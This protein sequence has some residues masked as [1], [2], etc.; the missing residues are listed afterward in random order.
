M[1]GQIIKRGDKTWLLRIF[2]GRDGS[3]KRR[4]KNKT[5]RGNKKDAEAFL[6]KTQTQ[7]SCGTFV[8][9][10]LLTIDEYLDKW[11]EAAARPRLSERTFADYSEVL[12]RYV[13][14][15]LGSITLS[16]LQPLEIQ[17]LYSE[18]Q[19]RELSARTVRGAHVVLSSALKQAVQWRMLF[20][21]PA[22]CVE[23]PK[24]TRR[25]MKA[26]SPV[27]AIAFLAAAKHDPHGLVFAVG[28]VTGMRPEEY[29][30]LQWKDVDLKR[31]TATVQR[32]LCWR[33]QKGGGWYFGEPKTSQSRRTVPLPST[34]ARKLG[35]H[36][37]GQAK[38]RLKKG[39]KY[40][41]LDLVFATGTG[42]PLHSENLATRNFR[43]IRNRAKLPASITPYSLRHTCA[44]LLLLAGE[45]PKVVSE[46]LGHSSVVM[47]LDTYSHV[48]P[49][50]QQ[51]AT[52][53]LERMLF[54]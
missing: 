11:L 20:V 10:S 6:R 27:E 4:Y 8:E 45:N 30:A 14:P 41:S 37:V 35:R 50:M 22:Q 33:R 9:P 48:L 12:T 32:T 18:M 7:I 42:G 13:R 36:K 40:Q 38:I 54:G 5:L 44:T 39:A 25:E 53:K 16:Q 1:A 2:M 19:G 43:V 21:N 31:G 51:A 52:E 29:L 24:R 34:I 26:L 3:G 28:L 15:K 47:T 23:L 49:C 17:G 46:R